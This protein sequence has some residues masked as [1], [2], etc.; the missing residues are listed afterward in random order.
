MFMRRSRKEVGERRIPTVY[1]A[2]LSY[3]QVIEGKLAPALH[4]GLQQFAKPPFHG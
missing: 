3:S 1:K 4:Y 2:F